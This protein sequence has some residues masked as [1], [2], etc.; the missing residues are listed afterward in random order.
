MTTASKTS[1]L[2][3]FYPPTRGMPRW[4][5]RQRDLPVAEK[6]ELLGRFIQETRQLEAVK[7]SCM[8]SLTSSNSSSPT[9]R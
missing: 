3:A 1:P 9:E 2:P 7:K 6:I 5:Q 4:R 8:P